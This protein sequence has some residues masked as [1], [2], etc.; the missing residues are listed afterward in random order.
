MSEVISEAFI[1]LAELASKD[2][3]APIN[4]LDGCWTRQIG[5][6]WWVAI[7]GHKEP[8]PASSPA[9]MSK[10]LPYMVQ[11]FHCYVEFNGWCAADFNPRGGAFAAGDA[12][13]ETTFIEAIQTEL[14]KS[15]Q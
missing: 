15:S 2:G 8:K 5:K 10:E 14:A 3:A 6:Q 12:A 9:G 4:Q 13:N 1:L 7:N 11:P